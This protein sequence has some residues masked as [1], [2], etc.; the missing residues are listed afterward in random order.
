MGFAPQYLIAFAVAMKV[1]GWVI[2]SSFS[3]TPN[4]VRATWSAA[5]PLTQATTYGEPV[6]FEISDS[7]SSTN[8]PTEDTNVES[9]QS[10]RY[11]FSFPSKIGSWRGIMPKL[12]ENYLCFG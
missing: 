9:I 6:N 7:N 10:E 11:F 8:L 2:T 5:V 12:P 4:K 3:S 1:S